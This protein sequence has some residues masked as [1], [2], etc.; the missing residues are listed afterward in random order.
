MRE[1]YISLSL[2]AAKWF[3]KTGLLNESIQIINTS[4]FTPAATREVV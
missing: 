1:P 4:E 3:I 2:R